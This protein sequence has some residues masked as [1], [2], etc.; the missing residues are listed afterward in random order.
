MGL[1]FR[2]PGYVV[3]G[4]HTL[5]QVVHAC[6]SISKIVQSPVLLSIFYY[7]SSGFNL[8]QSCFNIGRDIT[9][10]QV[11]NMPWMAH[12]VFADWRRL[13]RVCVQPPC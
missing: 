7:M 4:K 2:P 6:P 9:F 1:A 10:E 12:Q 8:Y 13:L 11:R 3:F 5:P